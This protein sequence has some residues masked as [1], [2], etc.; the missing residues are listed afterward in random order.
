MPQKESSVP[1]YLNI[2][3]ILINKSGINDE[4]SPIHPYLSEGIPA[5]SLLSSEDRQEYGELDWF[6]QN[7]LKM[8][9]RIVLDLK[10]GIP[11]EWERNYLYGH[12][13][14]GKYFYISEKM[15][16]QIFLLFFALGIIVPLVQERRI[17]L[18]FRKFKHQ[19][20]T[21]PVILYL[22]FQFFILSTLIIEEILVY[23][24]QSEL[25]AQYPLIFV[26]F[27]TSIVLL[28]SR[29]MLNILRGLP[30]PKSPHFYSYLAFIFALFNVLFGTFLNISYSLFFLWVLVCIIL[31]A[32][33]KGKRHKDFYFFL[34]LLPVAVFFLY[35]FR[36]S[37]LPVYSFFL[38]SRVKGNLILTV[39]TLP[40]TCMI[41]SLSY[42]HHHYEKSRHELRSAAGSIF[43][44]V[45]TLILSYQIMQLQSYTEDFPQ[46]VIMEDYQN[47]DLESREI[48]ISSKSD[49]GNGTIQISSDIVNIED[50]GKNFKIQGVIEEDL[51]TISKSTEVFLDRRSI[52]L[53][54]KALHPAG[55]DRG[56]DLIG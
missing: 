29:V 52:V 5:V 54:L 10:Q 14:G 25:V 38:L 20:W 3:S 35:I 48:H 16:I 13:P 33:A 8:L 45:L 6:I 32:I 41:T 17:Y 2:P 27:K 49:M 18:N 53:N 21:I 42:Y 31:F 50:A 26:L 28:L 39:L 43:M 47:L 51:L 22:T 55:R 56:Q 30:F 44:G 23:R 46:R 24:N 12:I 19:L 15:L 37:Y 34:S 40:F 1:I 9:N 11:D 4:I 36:R 7:Q